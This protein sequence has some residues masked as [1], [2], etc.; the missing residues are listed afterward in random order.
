MCL[1]TAFHGEFKV[2]FSHH[3]PYFAPSVLSALLRMNMPVPTP[4]GT[5]A[6]WPSCILEPTTLTICH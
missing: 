4:K 2:I 3:L 5:L 6:T 1:G